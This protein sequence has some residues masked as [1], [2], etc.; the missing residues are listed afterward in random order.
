VLGSTAMVFDELCH[1]CGMCERLCPAEAITEIQRRVGA[2]EV[3]EVVGRHDGLWVVTGRLD[4]GE[5]KTPN[6]IRATRTEA[7]RLDADVVILDAPPGVA[8]AAVA[9]I[10]G[11]NVVVHVA[12]PTRFGL[13]DL[14]LSVQLAE[15][16]GAT[17]V[18]VI[19]RLGTGPIDLEA[20]CAQHGMPVLA[21]I[22]FDRGIAETY[23]RGAI[24]SDESALVAQ[25]LAGLVRTLG[26]LG[27]GDPVTIRCEEN[28][29]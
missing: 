22:P 17:S 25:E 2:I 5:V 26:L 9:A 10:R 6:V 13:H 3:S 18:A 29:R 8:C 15:N 21:S 27:E 11:A 7:E 12:E 20:W 23:A 19:N 16:L 24:A 4:V 1:G 14:E 28:D